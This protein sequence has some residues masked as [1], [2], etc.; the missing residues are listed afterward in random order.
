MAISN[1]IPG[2]SL[3]PEFS[4]EG[5]FEAKVAIESLNLSEEQIADLNEDQT[6][7][8]KTVQSS[9]KSVEERENAFII[10]QQSLVGD[11]Y[12]MD[13]MNEITDKR[14]EVID[15]TTGLLAELDYEINFEDEEGDDGFGRF[16]FEDL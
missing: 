2:E 9:K 4:K 11:S 6:R 12:A 7:L 8:L 14:G 5:S 15:E 16:D 3:N 13:I 1:E 10:L